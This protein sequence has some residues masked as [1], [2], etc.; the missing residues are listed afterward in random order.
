MIKIKLS[1]LLGKHKMTRKKLAE[2]IDVR[3]NTIGD[4]YNEKVKKIDVETLDKICE[5]FECEVEDIIE[6]IRE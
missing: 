5:V 4:L 2:L 1:E 6:H 3:P